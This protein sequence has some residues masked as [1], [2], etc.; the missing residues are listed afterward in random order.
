MCET[1]STNNFLG[2][3]LE[4]YGNVQYFQKVAFFTKRAL[5]ISTSAI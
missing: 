1:F 2:P 5:K 3:N 4:Y